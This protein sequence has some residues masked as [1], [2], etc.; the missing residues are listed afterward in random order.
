[1]SPDPAPEQ[2]GYALT[3]VS[4]TIKQAWDDATQPERVAFVREYYEEI[5]ILGEQQR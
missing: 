2:P 4:R 5:K 3:R 1:L